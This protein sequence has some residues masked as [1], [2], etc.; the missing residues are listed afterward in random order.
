MQ[1][2]E[3]TRDCEAI[4]IPEG[5]KATLGKGAVVD[6]TQTLGGTYTVRAGAGLYRIGAQDADALGLEKEE[7]TTATDGPVTPEAVTEVLKTCF[8]PEIPVN[9]V[10][11]GL[12]YKIEIEE[13]EDEKRLVSVDMTLTAPG[14]GMGPVIA[15]DAEGK[16]KK[17][18]GVDD[19]KV[20]IVWDPPWTLDLISEVGKMELGLL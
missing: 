12:I 3:L 5:T 2:I 1:T 13:T 18:R 20:E 17:L 9:I 14:C 4:Q 10:D 15:A 6:I 16:I 8:D 7:T 11:L 19:A